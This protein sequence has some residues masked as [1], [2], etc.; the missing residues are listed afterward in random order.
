[1]LVTLHSYVS[2]DAS[3]MKNSRWSVS[4]VIRSSI[5]GFSS[6]DYYTRDR[7]CPQACQA[8]G[9]KRLIC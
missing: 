4:A 2:I 6:E 1:M 3:S 7:E 8:R 9:V 5:I